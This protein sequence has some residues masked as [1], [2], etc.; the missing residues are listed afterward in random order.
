MISK[1]DLLKEISGTIGKMKVLELTHILKRANFDMNDLIELTFNP[2]RDVAF[3]AAWILENMFL[4]SPERYLDNLDTILSR[5]QDVKHESC[6]RHYVKILMHVTGKKTPIPIRRK[7]EDIHLE[8]IV[9]QCFEWMIDPEIKI[10]VKCFSAEVLFNLHGR[11]DWIAEE[12]ANQLE[13]LMLD[14]GPGI[15]SKGKRLLKSLA[16]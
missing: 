12:L 7:L 2:N 5:L 4:Q 10:A 9:E 15:Q 6:Q 3:R 14:G 8:P 1:E 16:K 13:F 11:Y